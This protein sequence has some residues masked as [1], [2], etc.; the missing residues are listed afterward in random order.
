MDVTTLVQGKDATGF[1]GS[2][3]TLVTVR[4]AADTVRARDPIVIEG[5]GLGADSSSVVV[6]APDSVLGWRA[7][8]EIALRSNYAD[9]TVDSVAS[10]SVRLIYHGPAAVRFVGRV[11]RSS[12]RPLIS[13][14][15]ICSANDP[16]AG[17]VLGPTQAADTAAVTLVG[18]DTLSLGFTV[19]ALQAGLVRDCF[20]SLNATPLNPRTATR[21]LASSTS[22]SGAQHFSFRLFQNQPNPLVQSASIR[23]EIPTPGHARVELYDLLGRRVRVLADEN[24][25]GGQHGLSWNATDSRGRPLA[26]GVYLC[27]LSFG[28]RS[29]TERIVVLGQ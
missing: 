3:G 5:S 9:A 25:A 29:A 4:L 27:R 26:G 15:A 10:D 17:N 11:A 13:W 16:T 14:A 19:P 1:T 7:I 22:G 2:T 23:F 21:T 18:P 20:F 6:E 12:E 24:F 28:G 8:Q